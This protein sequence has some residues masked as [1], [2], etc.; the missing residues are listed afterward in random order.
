MLD[1][2]ILKGDKDGLLLF[3]KVDKPFDDI[4][5]ALK[6]KLEGS[7]E[8]FAKSSNPPII[9]YKGM[10]KLTNFE[11]EIFSKILSAY[12]L[13]Y[14][15]C[16]VPADKV[17]ISA[18][19]KPNLITNLP[20]P[21]ILDYCEKSALTIYRTVR[22][23]QEIKY[24]GSIIIIGDVNPSA[25]VMAENDIFV[26]G[27]NRGVLH[28]GMNGDKKSVIMA[29]NFSGGQ[30]RIADLIVSVHQESLASCGPEVAM[31]K[32]NQ[33]IISTMRR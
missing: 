23:G 16:F 26:V 21:K 3:V 27:S 2:I 14:E 29:G 6:T 28:A 11:N 22:G 9:R 31:V 24:D 12:G 15:N 17:Q 25:C 20:D 19:K 13:T 8:F 10:R 32:E 4:I 1:D 18:P 33:I 5:E 7:I 30:I